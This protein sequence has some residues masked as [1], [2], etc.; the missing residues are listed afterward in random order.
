MRVMIPAWRALRRCAHK[1][2]R[3]QAGQRTRCCDRGELREYPS[4]TEVRKC[5]NAATDWL[6]CDSGV[7]FWAF[8]VR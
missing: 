8:D 6:A 4:R 2:G 7:V 5:L 1:L 3:G